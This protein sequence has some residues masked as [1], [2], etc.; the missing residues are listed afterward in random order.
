MSCVF[1]LRQRA[2]ASAVQE[3]SPM[4]ATDERTAGRR[5]N[6]SVEFS[7]NLESKTVPFAQ[8]Y[9]IYIDRTRWNHE[10]L[11]PEYPTGMDA[12]EDSWHVGLRACVSRY[13][14]AFARA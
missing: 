4:E 14:S 12:S 2:V 10:S 13:T 6:G 3:L 11:Y 5:S 8:R 9:V 7:Q 1:Q